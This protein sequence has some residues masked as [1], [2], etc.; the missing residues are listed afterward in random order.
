M[1]TDT[2]LVD[3]GTDAWHQFRKCGIGSSE[4]AIVMGISPFRTKYQLWEEKLGLSTEQDE[5]K[6]KFILERGHEAEKVSRSKYELLN[7]MDMPPALVVHPE[8]PYIR[9]SMDGFNREAKKA[10]ELKLVG[11][12]SHADA[13]R[14]IVPPHYYAQCQHLM[15]ASGATDLDYGSFYIQKDAPDHSGELVIVPLKPDQ[16]FID[17][18][19]P[20]ASHF[21]NH[22]VLQ[23]IPP[24][25]DLKMDFKPVNTKG[26]T[27]LARQYINGIE[28]GYD[29]SEPAS[30]LR[31]LSE[32][33][34]RARF[35]KT[36]LRIING[37]FIF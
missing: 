36:S 12:E 17:S 9:A 11:A 14:G 25:F 26:V 18:Y 30:L 3:Q 4:C 27:A 28:N 6:N 15:L 20:R 21:W 7:F 5:P 10:L 34:V 1:H 13:K 22:H 8:L 31:I 2:I 24:P 32:G 16:S 35:G 19:L 37:E 29:V 33:H 23:K